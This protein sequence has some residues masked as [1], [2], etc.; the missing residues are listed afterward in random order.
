MSVNNDISTNNLQENLK[1]L[2]GTIILSNNF[3]YTNHKRLVSEVEPEI[4]LSRERKLQ[5]RNWLWWFPRVETTTSR[6]VYKKAEWMRTWVYS[7]FSLYSLT[8]TCRPWVGQISCAWSVKISFKCERRKDKRWEGV[9]VYIGIEQPSHF[10]LNSEQWLISL[11]V[12]ILI[13]KKRRRFVVA[14]VQN[15][16]TSRHVA[17]QI[18]ERTRQISPNCATLPNWPPKRLQIAK[19]FTRCFLC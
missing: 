8:W 2:R 9:F 19:I 11:F 7:C 3:Y 13:A 15:E 14:T 18:S 4:D 6:E 17:H 10:F 1:R 12:Y 5:W 16:L